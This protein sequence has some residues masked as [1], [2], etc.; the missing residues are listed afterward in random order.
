MSCETLTAPPA[1]VPPGRADPPAPTS[2]VAPPRTSSLTAWGL[3]VLLVAYAPVNFTFGSVNVLADAI[4][5]D[6]SADAAGQQLVLAAY[7]TAFAATLVIAGR[8]GDRWGRRRLLLIGGL[9]VG[10][11][12]VATAFVPDL[13]STVALR[14]LLGVTAG[15]LTPQV[16]AT[17]QSAS[18]GTAR[19]RG[20]MLFVAVS[21][22]ST[23]VGQIVAGTVAHALPEH[24]GWRAVQILTGLIALTAVAG[25]RTVPRTRSSAPLSLDAIGAS[26]LGASLL[27]IVVPLTIGRSLG[28]PSWTVVSL[29]VGVAL[30]AAFWALQRRSERRGTI[31]V[32]PPSVLRLTPVRRGL[33]M[34]LLFFMTYGAFLYEL[35]AFAQHRYAMG[36]LGPAL[37]VLGFGIAFIAASLALPRLIPAAG[38]LTMASAGLAQAV[39]LAAIAV[40]ISTGHHD[41]ASLQWALIP[42]GVAQALMFGPVLKTVLSR[43]P[44]WAA[45]VSSGLFATVQQLGLTLGVA[46]LGGLFWTLAG[47]E[48]EHLEHALVT[49]FWIH[50]G[51]ALLFVALA[52]SLRSHRET[53][54]TAE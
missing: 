36:P 5:R 30:L 23:V 28:W 11:I 35:S 8:L 29:L 34:T 1:P 41:I 52:H 19:T 24:L 2:S 40:L 15:L 12:S 33:L 6:L 54:P 53:A 46:L 9:G 20:L 27:L 45:G 21:G 4:G 38:E 13:T 22:A 44:Q 43:A 31:P 18:S 49:V 47:P 17:I 32:V 26:V 14:V 50:V 42:L 51:C 37:L 16:L 3:G 7:T 48:Q 39:I 25:L 10:V